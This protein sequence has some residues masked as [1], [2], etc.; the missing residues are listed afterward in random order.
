[1]R[2]ETPIKCGKVFEIM[3]L[4]SRLK[5]NRKGTPSSVSVCSRQRC[6]F[7]EITSWIASHNLLLAQPG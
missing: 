4:F 2:V 3:P 7:E 5:V 1:M 6:F